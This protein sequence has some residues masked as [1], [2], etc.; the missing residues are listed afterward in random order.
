MKSMALRPV[1]SRRA[2]ARASVFATVYLVGVL[3]YILEAGYERPVA[4]S[5]HVALQAYACAL[6]VGFFL[7][8]TALQGWWRV[9]LTW[10]GV[11]L[12]WRVVSVLSGYA[13]QVGAY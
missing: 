9:G 8:R 3:V 4:L 6:V 11:Y 12:L 10:L 2:I 5:L 7:R 13:N 1:D